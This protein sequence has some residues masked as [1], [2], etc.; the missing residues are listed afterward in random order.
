MT[1]MAAAVWVDSTHQ[2]LPQT[3]TEG[4]LSLRKI[5]ARPKTIKLVTRYCRSLLTH[6]WQCSGIVDVK[7]T[8]SQKHHYLLIISSWESETAYREAQSENLGMYL[9]LFT[10][11]LETGELKSYE[12]LN[13][14]FELVE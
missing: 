13:D 5:E 14:H 2:M 10:E 1:T 7:I 3:K 9:H 4:Y 11:W 6:F 8:M 12:E